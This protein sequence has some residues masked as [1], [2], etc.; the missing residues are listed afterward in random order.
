MVQ[1]FPQIDTMQVGRL[2]SNYALFD[3][4]MGLTLVGVR[5]PGLVGVNNTISDDIASSMDLAEL[6]E[7]YVC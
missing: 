4:Y 6:H 3:P 7:R 2:L 1:A 5:D